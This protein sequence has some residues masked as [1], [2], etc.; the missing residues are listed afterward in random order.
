MTEPLLLGLVALGLALAFDGVQ[1]DDR[2]L[3]Q[4]GF[5]ALALACLTRYESW[6]ITGAATA[7]VGVAV[8][9]RHGSI[10]S[11]VGEAVR[12]GAMPLA[13]IL[14]FFCQSKL[15]IGKWFVTG[16]FYVADPRYQGHPWTVTSAVWWGVC[17]LGSDTLATVVIVA[18]AAI[19]VVW[20]RHREHAALIVPLAWVGAA[21]LP[22]YAFFEGHPFR[23]RY[24]VPSVTAA[25]V[26]TGIAVGRLPR[27]WQVAAAAL[28]AAG[29]LWQAH[30]FD[31]KAPMVLEAQWDVPKGRAR[32]AVTACLP[33]AGGGEVVMASMGSL[34]HYMQELSH[35][36]FAIH[37]FLHEG[38]GDLWAAALE[39]PSRYVR[40]ILIEEVDE[41]GDVLAQRARRDPRFLAGFTRM[42]EGGGV[43]LYHVVEPENRE[44]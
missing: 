12:L 15:T 17:A 13:A 25:V 36:G 33:P 22:W 1:R 3:R 21:A 43:A 27:R 18:V 32:R 26:L 24:M 30:P 16:G 4:L 40:W 7:C 29:V 2:R 14:W 44:P 34:A 5:V 37:D 9:R 19:V 20:V 6:P 10:G 41:G 31:P 38:N 11:A 8:W 28:V 42:C 23:I 39:G 35:Q